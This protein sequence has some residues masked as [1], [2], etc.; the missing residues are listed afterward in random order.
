MNRNEFRISQLTKKL[1]LNS[2]LKILV[3][4]TI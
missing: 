4:S 1:F 2:E 3:K